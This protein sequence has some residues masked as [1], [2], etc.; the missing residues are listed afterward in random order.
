MG[1]DLV[2]FPPPQ[3]DEAAGFVKGGE[4]VFIEA[5]IAEL[6]IEAF[7]ESVLSGF[8]WGDEV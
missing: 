2:V 7:D 1:S 3:F 8:A 5:F 4:P 6:A